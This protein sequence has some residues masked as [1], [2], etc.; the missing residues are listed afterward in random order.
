MTMFLLVSTGLTGQKNCLIECS[1]SI[2]VDSL[3]T[4]TFKYKIIPPLNT[5]SII[6]Q[7]SQYIIDHKSIYQTE[8]YKVEIS[9]KSKNN[10]V[11]FI[12]GDSN[13][14]QNLISINYPCKKIYDSNSKELIWITL[15]IMVQPR[16]I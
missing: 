11:L 15:L 13:S 3:L 16:P 8:G 9:S 6:Y 14:A 10:S 4:V 12:T 2:T 7:D 1:D 5:N